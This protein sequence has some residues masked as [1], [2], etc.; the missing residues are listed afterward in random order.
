MIRVLIAEDHPIAREGLLVFLEGQPGIAVVAV[1]EDGEQAVA[2]AAAERPDVILMDVDM[3]G[4]DGIEATRRIVAAGSMASIVMLTAFSGPDWVNDALDAGAC[5]YVVKDA[6]PEELVRGVR[7]AAAGGSPLSP[8]VAATV[9][10]GRRGRMVAEQTL[11]P[12]EREVLRL[13]AAGLPNKVIAF[14]LEISEKTVKAHLTNVFQRIGVSDRTQA[15]LWA[16]RNG[17]AELHVAS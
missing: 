2:L 7:A 1:A 15:A 4:C 6:E 11:S 3:P 16:H 9:L 12:R 8:V 17:L 10:E 13:V 5:G 14:R